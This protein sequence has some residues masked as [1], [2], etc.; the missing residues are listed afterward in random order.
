MPRRS[1]LLH[2]MALKMQALKR[3]D[4]AWRIRSRIYNGHQTIHNGWRCYP[5]SYR[6]MPRCIIIACLKP[7][8][9]HMKQ[10][11]QTSP[12]PSPSHISHLPPEQPASNAH[13]ALRNPYAIL[14]SKFPA[15]YRNATSRTPT[16]SWTSTSKTSEPTFPRGFCSCC[17]RRYVKPRSALKQ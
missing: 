16:G 13:K 12:R 2:L 15:D 14:T 6:T 17:P 5:R 10:Q 9:S 4:P 8:R 11:C 7:T 1:A 3:G